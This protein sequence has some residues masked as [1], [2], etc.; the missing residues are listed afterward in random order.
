MDEELREK[1]VGVA[2]REAHGGT[3]SRTRRNTERE[4]L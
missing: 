3:V 2:C 4:K 1:K